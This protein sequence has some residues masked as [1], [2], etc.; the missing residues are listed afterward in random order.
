MKFNFDLFDE[1]KYP[2]QEALIALV[3]GSLLISSGVLIGRQTVFN[4]TDE[5]NDGDTSCTN[6]LVQHTTLL[7]NVIAQQLEFE[8]GVANESTNRKTGNGQDKISPSQH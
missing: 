6:E 2:T 7:T 8:K 4:D 3:I 5:F 1:D